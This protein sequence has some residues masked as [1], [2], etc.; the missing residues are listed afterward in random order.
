MGTSLIKLERYNEAIV[1]LSK[2]IELNPDYG[3]AYLNRGNAREMIRDVRGACLD[4]KQA[5]NL[6][7]IQAKSFVI[8]CET[9]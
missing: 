2:A 7:Q 1:A 3:E 6:G 9:E 4:W 8:F 5:I